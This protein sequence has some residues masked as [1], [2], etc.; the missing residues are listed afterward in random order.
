MEKHYEEIKVG[1]IKTFLYKRSKVDHENS[2][3]A[4]VSEIA[5]S[6][7]EHGVIEPIIVAKKLTKLGKVVKENCLVAGYLRVLA[8]QQA[9]VKT[10]PAIVFDSLTMLQAMDK[11]LIENL[12]RQEMADV[13]VANMLGVYVDMGLANKDIAERIHRSDAYVS[14]YLSLLQDTEPIREALS[15]RSEDFTEKHARLVRSLPETLHKEAVDVVKGKT[16]REAKDEVNKI[17]EEN[18]E[19]MIKQQL[20]EEQAKITEIDKAEKEKLKLDDDIAKLNGKLEGLKTDNKEMNMLIHKIEVLRLRYYPAL[21]QLAKKTARVKEITNMMP[22]YKVKPLQKQREDAYKTIAKLDAQITDLRTQIKELRD[23]R[24][25]L[26]KEAK[27]RTEKISFVTQLTHEKTK[28]EKEIKDLKETT[29]EFESK[30][31]S[32]IANFDKIKGQVNGYQ[33]KIVE[34]RKKILLQIGELKAKGRQLNGK[35]ANRKL[36]E[37]RISHLEAELK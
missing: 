29:Q 32:A 16:V 27:Q 15:E 33:A 4:S 3:G 17:A 22:K 24:E 8:T 28:L 36:V 11:S 1:D 35:I 5:E 23:K 12:H 18:K 9:K 34:K 31:K 30:Y 26:K 37:K 2:H 21:E 10:I 13:D 25:T 7:K 14:L 20:T 6:I 19:A